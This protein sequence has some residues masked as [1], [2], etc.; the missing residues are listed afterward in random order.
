M[1]SDPVTFLTPAEYL[2]LERRAE[3]KSEYYQGETFAMACASRRH[4]LI[5]TNLVGELRQQLKGRP[6]QAYSTDLRLNITPTGLYTYPDVMVVCGDPQ[7]TDDQMDTLINPCLII[8][9]LSESTRDY[10]RGRKFEHFRTLPSLTEYL[11]MAQ[12]WPHVEQWTRL[13][14]KRWLLSEFD[15]L[16][17]CIQL[18]SIGCALPL[19]EV[20]DKIDWPAPRA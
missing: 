8:E 4:V 20:Y 17:Q 15:Q 10:D 19:A 14:E 1:S 18:A 12:D 6:C 9:V 2:E 3:S 13:P 11:T 7:F 16:S 5:V